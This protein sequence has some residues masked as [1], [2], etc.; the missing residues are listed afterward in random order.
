MVV[1]EEE[2]GAGEGKI[3]RDNQEI[4]SKTL[5][6]IKKEVQRSKTPFFVCTVHPSL[7]QNNCHSTMSL[8]TLEI[9]ALHLRLQRQ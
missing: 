8:S 7:Y 5:V 2:D 4:N 3:F 9:Q 6:C 1:G